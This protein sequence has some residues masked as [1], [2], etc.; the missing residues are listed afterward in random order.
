LN[1]TIFL[2]SSERGCSPF[3]FVAPA[4]DVEAAKAF[5]FLAYHAFI[6]FWN[7]ECASMERLGVGFDFDVN[8]LGGKESKG[9]LEKEPMF[10]EQGIEFLLLLR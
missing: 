5:D 10:V 1:L 3:A 6:G 7:R 9:A 2:G 8:R 4:E